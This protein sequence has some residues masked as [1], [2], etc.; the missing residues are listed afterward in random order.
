MA[1]TI[2][3]LA[4]LTSLDTN[5]LQQGSVKAQGTLMRL[6][7]SL[8]SGL[9]PS[10][11][12]AGLALGAVAAAAYVAKKGIDQLLEASARIDR[13]DELAQRYNLEASAVQGLGLAA[14]LGATDQ[15]TLMR[16]IQKMSMTVGSGGKSLDRRFVEI[17]EGISK[18]EDPGLRATKIMEIFGKSGLEASNLIATGA[19]EVKVA[20]DLMDRYNIALTEQDTAAISEMN[21]EWDKLVFVLEG[22]WNKFAVALAPA[23]T[24]GLK[25]ILSGIERVGEAFEATGATWDMVGGIAMVVMGEIVFW[26]DVV[27]AATEQMMSG[28]IAAQGVLL[29]LGSI[30]T[31]VYDSQL[32]EELAFDAD[33]KYADAADL[34]KKSMGGGGRA[35]KGLGG[36]KGSSN[37][38]SET[39]MAY[40]FRDSK[41]T[42]VERGSLDEM[43]L[44]MSIRTGGG[45]SPSK[46]K[47][48]ETAD[49]T[50]RAADALDKMLRDPPGAGLAAATL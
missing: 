3:K 38:S 12:S 50:R 21:D 23:M 28:F 35:I 48:A 47:A 18:I 8:G 26:I 4:I 49:N 39:A 44:L 13:I 34:F 16:A 7:G 36:D 43:K 6:S 2:T 20:A 32:S 41:A 19:A 5:G 46:D 11:G 17:A 9:G 27:V 1:T 40:A 30:A 15:E 31:S 24:H 45:A 14:K 33:Q 42:G 37:M 10:A 22:I 25:A 29:D